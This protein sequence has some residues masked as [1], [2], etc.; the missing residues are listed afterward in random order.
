MGAYV[1]SIAEVIIVNY[2]LCVGLAGSGRER[3]Y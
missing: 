2:G 3:C 1:G